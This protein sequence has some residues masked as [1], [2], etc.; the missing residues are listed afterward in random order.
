MD[1]FQMYFLSESSHTQKVTKTQRQNH[2]DR[3]QIAARCWYGGEWINHKSQHEGYFAR[4]GMIE[5]FF[6]LIM[7]LVK[8]VHQN[9]WILLYVDFKI[10]FLK[11]F[12]NHARRKKKEKHK[13]YSLVHVSGQHCPARSKER[14]SLGPAEAPLEDADGGLPA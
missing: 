12:T 13:H 11:T 4:W 2:R 10:K 9:K 1:E 14:V 8:T 6:I 5:L 7:G 3:E